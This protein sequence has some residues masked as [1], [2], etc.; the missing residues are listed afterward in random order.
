MLSTDLNPEESCSQ[1]LE[2][3]HAK[4]VILD[5]ET[6]NSSEINDKRWIWMEWIELHTIQCEF[7]E[8]PKDR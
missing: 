6:F 2:I 8:H 4:T 5:T 1:S 3:R 7:Q